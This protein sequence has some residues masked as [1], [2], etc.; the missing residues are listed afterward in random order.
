MNKVDFFHSQLRATSVLEDVFNI[1]L[2]SGLNGAR[3]LRALTPSV[4]ETIGPDLDVR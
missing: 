2:D 1:S 4:S 3:V